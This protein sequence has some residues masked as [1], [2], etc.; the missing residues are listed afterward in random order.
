VFENVKTLAL[1]LVD[2]EVCE[3]TIADVSVLKMLT[4]YEDGAEIGGQETVVATV[5]GTPVNAVIVVDVIAVGGGVE[6][7]EYT[8]VADPTALLAVSFTA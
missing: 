3:Y 1:T 8:D 6:T 5:P 7:A 4:A 2:V